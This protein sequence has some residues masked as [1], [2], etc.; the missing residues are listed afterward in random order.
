MGNLASLYT[1]IEKEPASSPIPTLPANNIKKSLSVTNGVKARPEDDQENPWEHKIGSHE[2]TIVFYVCYLL[3]ILADF[4]LFDRI[5]WRPRTN[6]RFLSSIPI[7][8]GVLLL[9]LV[10]YV[11]I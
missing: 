4:V 5:S 8:F 2:I 6:L 1:I 10:A 9:S 11:F 3:S 7:T